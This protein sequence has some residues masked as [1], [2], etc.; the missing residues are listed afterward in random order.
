MIQTPDIHGLL[1]QGENARLEFIDSVRETG[2][3]AKL[4]GAFANADGGTIVI[5]IREPARII[6]IEDVEKVRQLYERAIEKLAPRPH[7]SFATIN[8][9]G[10][11]IAVVE[12]DKANGLVLAENGAYARVGAATRAMT[13]NDVSQALKLAQA[14]QP[15]QLEVLSRAIAEQTNRIE[16]LST[17]LAKAHSWHGKVIDYVIGGIVGAVLGYLLSLFA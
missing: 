17:A 5:G 12:V 14:S 10:K 16:D 13:P 7:M 1:A 2:E 9:D 15:D 3:L 8:V 6:G 11:D 4:I